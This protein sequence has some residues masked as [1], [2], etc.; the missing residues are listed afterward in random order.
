MDS[1][2]IY[3]PYTSNGIGRK[4]DGCGCGCNFNWY[5]YPNPL[6]RHQRMLSTTKL[7]VHTDKFVGET[8]V[9]N[10]CCEPVPVKIE[11]KVKSFIIHAE[12]ECLEPDMYYTLYLNHPIGD[13]IWELP[14][15]VRVEKCN[16]FPEAVKI[17]ET[18]T[19]FPMS[20]FRGGEAVDAFNYLKMADGCIPCDPAFP[21]NRIVDGDGFDGKDGFDRKDGCFC[22]RDH[23]REKH[24]SRLIPVELDLHGNIAFGNNYVKNCFGNP[25]L[26]QLFYTNRRTFSLVR[27]YWRK[28]DY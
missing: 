4:F 12:T 11:E 3:N 24:E 10:E 20:C 7:E 18:E 8:C 17:I 9:K 28:T 13:K 22:D 1:R 14:S 23:D 2:T 26:I 27:P 6:K 5:A 16:V 15:F 19:V 25:K 21:E